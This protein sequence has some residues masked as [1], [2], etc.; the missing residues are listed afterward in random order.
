MRMTLTTRFTIACLAAGFFA[1]LAAAGAENASASGVAAAASAP[2]AN[3]T[4]TS[5]D[6][7]FVDTDLRLPGLAVSGGPDSDLVEWHVPEIGS[8]L[9]ERAALVLAANGLTGTGVLVPAPALGMQ[10]DLGAIASGQPVLLLRIATI[11]KST[12]RLFTK[13]G[14]IV[15]DAQLIDGASAAATPRW[16]A[17]LGGNQLGFDPVLGVLKTNRVDAAWVDSFLKFVLDRL[18]QAGLVQLSGPKAIGPK[19]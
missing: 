18:A 11:T 12:P 5:L 16:R 1:P 19:G 10:P 7:A 8:L 2:A 4:L 6:I 14:Q 9:R 3:A 13:A 15:F 17:Q